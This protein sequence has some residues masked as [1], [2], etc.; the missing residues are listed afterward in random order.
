[1]EK[2]ETYKLP[3]TVLIMT[4]NE[5]L[6]IA[7]TL[8]SIINY[9]TQIIV[10]DSNSVD[11]TINICKN[12][13]SVETYNN[14]FTHWATQRNW[15]LENCSI[16]NDW[17]FFLDADESINK[18]FFSE[19][20]EKFHNKKD[21]IN[22][23]FINKDLYFLGKKLK[24]S[25][26]HPKIR[27]IFKRNG[28]KYHAEGAREFASSPGNSLEIKTPLIH[29]DKRS[30]DHWIKKHINNADREMKLYFEK[31]ESTIKLEYKNIPIALKIRKYIRN[32]IWSQL[33]FAI[34]PFLYFIYRYIFKLGF[35]DG[36]Y[37]FIFCLNHALWYELL[38]D[39]KIIEKI[40]NDK[41]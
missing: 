41:K 26:N 15:M 27:L 3:I 30:F 13:T 25:Y 17:V 38:I 8:E 9:F 6:N 36:K 11:N 28:L 34:R 14:T 32:N 20:Q 2:T 1:M 21:D 5:E 40:N 29:E 4:Q 31:K 19:L 7:N 10:V 16:I 22:S 24:F 12:Y 23:F 18:L 35:L 37:G 39:I 33:P